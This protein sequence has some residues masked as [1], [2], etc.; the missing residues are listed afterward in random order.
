MRVLLVEDHPSMRFAIS[1]AV[2]LSGAGEV[3]G[4]SDNAKEALKLVLALQPDLVVLDLRL[5]RETDGAELCRDIKGVPE[6]PRVL[7]YTSYSA[8]ADIELCLLAGADGFVHKSVPHEVLVRA[9]EK[10]GAGEPV[11][12]VG[13]APEQA[14]ARLEGLATGP[15]L[16]A[17]EKEILNLVL[18]RYSNERIAQELHLSMP[19][20]KTH[21][22]NI[23][24]KR[25]AKN[26]W[27][28]LLG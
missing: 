26:R 3:V 11:G 23:L 4:E 6:A 9:L 19:T 13:E 20:V 22:R 21:M 27:E 12:L 7:V 10:T 1:A 8:P 15:P 16:T 2:R 25:R 28:L 18:R 24:R 14:R 17:R 5:K